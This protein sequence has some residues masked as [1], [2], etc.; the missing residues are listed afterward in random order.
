[1]LY[2]SICGFPRERKNVLAA[3]ATM[4]S[5]E[6]GPCHDIVPKIPIITTNMEV[7]I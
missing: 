5:K 2:L 4:M 6:I 7:D 3:R 1:M